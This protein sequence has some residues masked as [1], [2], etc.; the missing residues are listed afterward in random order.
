M[1]NLPEN[2]IG[3]TGDYSAVVIGVSAGG[4]RILGNLLSSLPKDLSMPVIIVQHGKPT[5]DDF[6]ISHFNEISKLGVSEAEEKEKIK[7]GRIYFAP[8]GYHLLIEEDK[9]FAL[10]IDEKVNYSRPS[11]DVL[12]ECAA[13]AYGS[14]LIGVPLTGANNDG[15]QGMR[16]IY[17][18]GGLTVVQDPKEAEY[19]CMPQAAI[20]NVHVHHILPIKKILELLIKLN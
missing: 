3:K 14:N 19:S 12:F 15:A 2:N 16:S 7:P 13:D 6:L 8:L 5:D 1:E 11:I 17:E 9:T 20:D 4:M 10:T 18:K